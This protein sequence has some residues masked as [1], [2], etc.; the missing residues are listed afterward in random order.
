MMSPIEQIDSEEEHDIGRKWEMETV[1]IHYT[2]I[3][4]E[5]LISWRVSVKWE[6]WF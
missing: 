3:E 2:Y 6:T 4:N 1:C 5:L